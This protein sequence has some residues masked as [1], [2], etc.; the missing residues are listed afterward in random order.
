MDTRPQT[1]R[2]AGAI[3]VESLLQPIDGA[4][5]A[6]RDLMDADEYSVIREHRRADV[7]IVLQDDP[8]DKS[9]RLFVKPD[10]KSS[11][12]HAVLR[13]GSEA[14]RSKTK[15][16]QIAAWITEALGHLHGFTGLRDGFQLMRQLQS[17][18]G[19]TSTHGSSPTIRSRAM[20]RTTFS[21]A[22]S[23]YRS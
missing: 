21:T 18:S 8:F 13:L 19:P 11:D 1:A 2:G 9:R 15:D 7:D 10:Q 22:R 14:L 4:N 23:S 6:G 17:A 5:P 16:L 3:D 12:W 20:A